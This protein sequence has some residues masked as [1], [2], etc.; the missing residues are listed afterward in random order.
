MR[1]SGKTLALAL[2]AVAVFAL[3]APGAAFGPGWALAKETKFTPEEVVRR[4][5]D[6]P[7]RYLMST[8]E[9]VEVKK[10]K[11]LPE[12]SKF[13]TEFWRRRDPSPGTIENEF[14]RTYW[15][16]VLEAEKRFRDSTTPG[17]KSDRGKIFVLLGEPIQVVVDEHPDVANSPTASGPGK[18]DG[19]IRGIERWSYRRQ[20]SRVAEPEFVVAFVRDASLDWRL[21][22]N[23]DLISPDFPGIDT[24]SASNPSF[25]GIENRG[26]AIQNQGTNVVTGTDPATAARLTSR[27]SISQ[28]VAAGQ[29]P[30]ADTSTFANLDLGL[31][32]AVP[33][34]A[35]E[36]I[37]IVNAQGFLTGF[38]AVPRFEYFRAADGT[39]FVNIGGLIKAKDL[40]GD[41]HDGAS[42]LRLYATAVPESGSGEQ[43]YASNEK[44][45]AAV[46]LAKEP[47]PGGTVDIWTGMALKPGRYTVTLALEDALTSRIGRAQTKLVVPDFSGSGLALSS[48]VLAS[49]L[50]DSGDRLGV[51]ARA[52][53]VFKRSEDFGLYYEVYGAEQAAG[54]VKFDLSYQFFQDV[55]EGP[56]P[57]GRPLPFSD[58][59]QAVQGWSF[60]LA[61]W[62]VGRYR[63]EVTV[64][65]AAGDSTTAQTSFEVIE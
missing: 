21:S 54:G 16:R 2:T 42:T 1:R 39:T 46:D 18:A 26:S 58:R 40:Y 19:G 11:S 35:Q 33:S 10:L 41:M 24:T 7:V 53:G 3:F 31:E 9:E 45:P 55:P 23:P 43:R 63:V 32:L 44:A 27:P 59:D 15:F 64:S 49:A 12:L 5:A 30:T 47:P 22:S 37:A 56:K 20:Y 57:I 65:T 60:P 17:W 48:L 13:I 14:R 51:T 34:P 25:G 6:G 62:P 8:S 52:S 50:S 36:A 61:K 4:W 38:D 28:Q 29:P